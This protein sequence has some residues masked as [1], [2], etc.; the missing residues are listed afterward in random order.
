VV[1]E[2]ESRES[3]GEGEGTA[4]DEEEGEHDADMPALNFQWGKPES[5]W[6]R[7]IRV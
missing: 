6:E 7:G 3:E 1:R 4:T 2:A 5:F